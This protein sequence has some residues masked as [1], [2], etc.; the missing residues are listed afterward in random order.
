MGVFPDRRLARRLVK[1]MHLTIGG[2]GTASISVVTQRA[3]IRNWNL[4][5]GGNGLNVIE[6]P[7]PEIDVMETGVTLEV[8]VA[9]I[10]LSM[11]VE[12]LETINGQRWGKDPHAWAAWLRENPDFEMPTDR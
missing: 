2:F 12:L 7:D 10:E 11:T 1:H 3:Y 5:S 6:V 9:T 4:I 8:R